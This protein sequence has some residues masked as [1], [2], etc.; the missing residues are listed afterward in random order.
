MALMPYGTSLY[1]YCPL[2]A[3]PVSYSEV[4]F[5]DGRGFD[6]RYVEPVMT[7]ADLAATAYNRALLP[8]GVES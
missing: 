3:S 1:L 4:A 6:R 2:K 7:F 5:Q 8:P